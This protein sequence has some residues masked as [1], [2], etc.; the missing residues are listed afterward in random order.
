MSSN[1]FPNAISWALSVV[2][3][4]GCALVALAGVAFVPVAGGVLWLLDAVG[5]PFLA[6][7]LLGASVG[8]SC[9]GTS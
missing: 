7:F 9:F 4:S 3:R 1:D 6:V 2:L 5:L 8:S